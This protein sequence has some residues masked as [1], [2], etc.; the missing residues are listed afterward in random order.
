MPVAGPTYA[1]TT[2]LPEARMPSPLATTQSPEP[3]STQIAASSPE[4][5]L[6]PSLRLTGEPRILFAPVVAGLAVLLT[7]AWIVALV[8]LARW[9]LSRVF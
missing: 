7:T 6:A 1:E 5:D 9:I 2:A 8:V 4:P 3:Q